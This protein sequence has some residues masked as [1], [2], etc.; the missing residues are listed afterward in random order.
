LAAVVPVAR[1]GSRAI[2]TR[3][4]ST[5]RKWLAV[6]FVALGALGA[7]AGSATAAPPNV[8]AAQRLCE[9]QNAV[10]IGLTFSYSCGKNSLTELF[11]AGELKAAAGVCRAYGGDFGVFDPRVYSCTSPE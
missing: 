8:T 5:V 1:D 9:T 2:Q 3:G 6:F 7:G 10:F 4:G 11:T